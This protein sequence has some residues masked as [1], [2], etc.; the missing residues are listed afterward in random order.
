MTNHIYSYCLELVT[1]SKLC[2][3]TNKNVQPM[4]LI[5]QKRICNRLL[6]WRENGLYKTVTLCRFWIDFQGL[7]FQSKMHLN[8][9]AGKT[10][11]TSSWGGILV[12]SRH[13]MTNWL[14]NS[15]ESE[16]VT[17]TFPLKVYLQ[18]RCGQICLLR[19]ISLAEVRI[20][21]NSISCKWFAR[22]WEF[23]QMMNYVGAQQYIA[24]HYAF[25]LSR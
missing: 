15:P 19:T 25:L 12:L 16:Q 9:Q 22:V 4:C 8:Q 24:S 6:S 2:Q 3:K 18:F 1:S 7:L 23:W 10:A 17:I 11:F 5:L 14:W 21:I 20:L 13:W